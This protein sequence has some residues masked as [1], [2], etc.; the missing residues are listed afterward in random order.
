MESEAGRR[1]QIFHAPQKPR[2]IVGPHPEFAGQLQQRAAELGR[3]PNEDTQFFGMFGF[4]YQLVQFIIAID[5]IIGDAVFLE[6]R[7]GMARQTYRRHEMANGIGET[8]PYFF[9]FAQGSGIEVPDSGGVN[10]IEYAR[11]GVCLH[12]VESVARKAVEE[13][14]RR[15][16]EPFGE[17][18]IDRIDR[19]QRADSL[20]D[21]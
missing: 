4:G 6:C 9:D 16:S 18:T 3:E 21:R 2:R 19:L 17:Q 7:F 15:G 20:F 14:F 8:R 11:I 5:D 12:G 13:T 1:A 10:L